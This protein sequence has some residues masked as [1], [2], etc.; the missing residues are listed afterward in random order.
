MKTSNNIVQTYISLMIS[1]QE[2]TKTDVAAEL[3][4]IFERSSY[5]IKRMNQWLKG[6]VSLPRDVYEYM[7]QE[8]MPYIN[9]M[10]P[11]EQTVKL[12]FPE[13]RYK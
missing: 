6:D 9:H 8:L 5:D 12:S 2:M 1:E 10:T 13:R 11:E 3:S 7:L 4:V